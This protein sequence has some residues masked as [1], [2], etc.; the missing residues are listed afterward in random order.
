MRQIDTAHD[1]HLA[2]WAQSLY[3]CNLLVAPGLAFVGLWWLWARHKNTASP[4][5]RQHLRQALWGSVVAGMLIVCLSAALLAVGGL[6]GPWTWVGVI[7]YFICVHSVLV[8]VGMFALAKAMA[9]QP[10]RYPLI[11]LRD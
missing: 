10:W 3:L 7:T 8:L 6:H 9:G 11:G 5:A 2:V 1:Q 4:L